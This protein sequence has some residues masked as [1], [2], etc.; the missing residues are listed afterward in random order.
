MLRRAGGAVDA[1]TA[2]P[3]GITFLLGRRVPT[4]RFTHGFGRAEDVA[5]VIVV[6][7]IAAS[8]VA[9]GVQSVRRLA[10]PVDVDYLGAVAVAA[11]VGF[12]ANEIAARV[13]DGMHAPLWCP[14]R[15]AI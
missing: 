13:A 8:A 7:V 14:S 12:V 11:V 4:R 9:A 15:T 6:L 1:L 10:D 5:G 3:V 2:V